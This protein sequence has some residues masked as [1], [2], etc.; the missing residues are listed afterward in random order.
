MH[1]NRLWKNEKRICTLI[2]DAQKSYGEAWNKKVMGA[3]DFFLESVL[4]PPNRFRPPNKLQGTVSKFLAFSSSFSL[5][6]VFKH[7]FLCIRLSELVWV[8]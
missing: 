6:V 2:W 7:F 8:L 5:C 1:I 3:S 4:V